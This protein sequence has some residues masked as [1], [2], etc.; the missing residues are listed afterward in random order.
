MK[1]RKKQRNTPRAAFLILPRTSISVC[2]VYSMS[3]RAAFLTH[4]RTLKKC[5]R[6]TAKISVCSL[7]MHIRSLWMAIRS[8]WM[9]I[10][11][12]QTEI[13]VSCGGNYCM[14]RRKL[15]YATGRIAARYVKNCSM[16]CEELRHAMWKIAV[17]YVKNYCTPCGRIAVRNVKNCSTLC[18]DCRMLC[19]R[20]LY[21][22]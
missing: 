19:G 18:E 7:W 17:C 21:A 1:R 22:A 6:I 16:P 8:L 20:L 10:R 14:L 9:A 2:R 12:L 11:R 13:S 4:P 5:I 15:L 3:P